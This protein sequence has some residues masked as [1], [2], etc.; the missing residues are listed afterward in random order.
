M[1]WRRH[2][3]VLATATSVRGEAAG[4]RVSASLAHFPNATRRSLSDGTGYLIQT[5]AELALKGRLLEHEGVKVKVKSSIFELMRGAIGGVSVRG[6]SWNTPLS[7]SCRQMKVDVGRTAID[8]SALLMKRKIHMVQPAMGDATLI[9]DG[10][11]LGNL[12]NHPLFTDK[13]RSEL[14]CASKS[15]RTASE[16]HAIPAEILFERTGSTVRGQGVDLQISWGGTPIQA[17]LS[18]VQGKPTVTV[19]AQATGFTAPMALQ[20]SRWLTSFFNR[21]SLD[22]DGAELSFR[23]VRVVEGGKPNSHLLQL[24]LGVCVRSFPGMDINFR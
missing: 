12:L 11:D 2:L 1:D 6:L 3:L 17:M 24:G 15:R 4:G 16:P 9:L 21:L 7:L 10:R 20:A 5:V 14:V 18:D 13:M 8:L 23:T 22:L 19:A